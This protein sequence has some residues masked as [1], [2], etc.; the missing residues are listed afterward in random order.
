MSSLTT[1]GRLLTYAWKQR[2]EVSY[3]N[4]HFQIYARKEKIQ[5]FE[6][7]FY[8]HIR[9]S[10][11]FI[12]RGSLHNKNMNCNDNNNNDVNNNNHDTDNND[13]NNN[14]DNNS[15]NN[16]NNN[17]NYKDN[18]ND[19]NDDDNNNKNDN[20]NVNNNTLEK[21]NVTKK[22]YENLTIFF[23]YVRIGFKRKKR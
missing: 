4:H 19:N 22:F 11:S 18:S 6:I 16:S 13:D 5:L 7:Q 17:A 2:R 10:F 8:K 1:H 15:N 12:V 21:D 14:A 9:F 3:P 20:N 23:T